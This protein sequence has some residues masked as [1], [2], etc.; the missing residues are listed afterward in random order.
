M[1]RRVPE[2]P[3]IP[4]RS[5]WGGE[6]RFVGNRI[7]SI[8]SSL[9]APASPRENS[10]AHLSLSVIICK[11]PW[12]VSFQATDPH[13]F[14]RIEIIVGIPRGW[15]GALLPLANGLNEA[16]NLLR[17]NGVF[18]AIDG[19]DL[20]AD[21]VFLDHEVP[22]D[23]HR[24][25]R[26]FHRMVFLQTDEDAIVKRGSRAKTAFLIVANEDK[27]GDPRLLCRGK[28]VPAEA[29]TLSFQV[30]D[31]LG[32]Q[33]HRPGLILVHLEFDIVKTQPLD[34][35]IAFVVGDCR[36]GLG[37]FF[38]PAGMGNGDQQGKAQSDRAAR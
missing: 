36:N 7:L 2:L 10:G 3:V 9:R 19:H 25:N 37:A 6:A 5:I 16:E 4:A 28:N 26:E 18:H 17:H 23:F 31:G 20:A 29:D 22:F 38:L 12:Q 11:V 33:V 21:L 34:L 24:S 8:F 15:E 27:S 30:Q 14:P 1:T 13:G 32:N 35:L